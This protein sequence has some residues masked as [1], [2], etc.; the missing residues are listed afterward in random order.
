MYN[1][2]N[3][4]TEQQEVHYTRYI[5]S[6]MRAGGHICD[7]YDEQ[8]DKW[9]E[10]NGVNETER[11]EIEEM[12]ATGKMELE[13]SARTYIKAQNEYYRKLA[14][15]RKLSKK[16]VGEIK[17]VGKKMRK[18]GPALKKALKEAGWIK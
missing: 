7:C 4:K 13:T 8:F 3:K 18:T 15:E 11:C 1:F 12:F 16:V 17:E 5:I 14:E 6:W 10:A 9:L 2:E